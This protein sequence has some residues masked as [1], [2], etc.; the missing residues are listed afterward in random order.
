MILTTETNKQTRNNNTNVLLRDG[1]VNLKQSTERAENDFSGE[2]NRGPLFASFNN[3]HIYLYNN[4]NW[5]H[6]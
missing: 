3:E 4:K 5:L 1:A 6:W 2:E